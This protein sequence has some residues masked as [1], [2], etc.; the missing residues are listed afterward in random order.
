MTAGAQTPAAGDGLDAVAGWVQRL[1]VLLAAGLDPLRALRS[2]ENPPPELAGAASSESAYDV[3]ARLVDAASGSAPPV[4]GAWAA[5]A[6]AW[7]VALESGAPLAGALERVAESLHAL[8]DADRQV[9]LAIAGPVATAR[10]V[11]LLPLVGLGMGLLIG[12]DPLGVMLGTIPGAAAGLA[13]AALLAVGIRWNRRLVVSARVHDP[14]AG[15]G[16]ELL[17]IAL[18]GGG[19]PQSTL[20]LVGEAARRCSIGLELEEAEET[21]AFAQRAGVA[22]SALLRADASRVRRLVL[23]RELRRA[24]LLASRLLAPLGLCFLPAFVLLGVVPLV[25][26][27]LRGTLGAFAS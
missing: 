15:L 9:D 19:T 25:V 24:S 5:L 10:I 2:I 3:P 22:V 12:A 26:G 13:G 20:E 1:S 7:A 8:A 14:L 6:C 21:L 23:T 4:R 17:A 11:A 27:I 18:E 16:A